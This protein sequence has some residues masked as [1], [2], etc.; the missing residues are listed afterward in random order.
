MSRR[1]P[2]RSQD[3]RFVPGLLGDRLGTARLGSLDWNQT[4]SR[5][6]SRCCA[7]LMLGNSGAQE[8]SEGVSGVAIVPLDSAKRESAHDVG[9]CA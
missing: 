7:P 9:T 2:N 5:R 6:F 3:F 4:D 1:R 8:A